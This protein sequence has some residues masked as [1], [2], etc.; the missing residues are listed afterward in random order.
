MQ[1][2][3]PDRIQDCDGFL[4]DIFCHRNHH[5]MFNEKAFSAQLLTDSGKPVIAGGGPFGRAGLHGTFP[6]SSQ[7]SPKPPPIA[8][9]GSPYGNIPAKNGTTFSGIGHFSS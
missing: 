4:S 6:T 7:R 3:I 2:R 8:L 5:G 9:S 1:E